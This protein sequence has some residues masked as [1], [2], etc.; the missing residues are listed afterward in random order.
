MRKPRAAQVVLAAAA[1]ALASCAARMASEPPAGAS[2]AG[3][4]KLD[5]AASDDPQKVL[6]KMRAEAFKI[7]ARQY[8]QAQAPAPVARPGKR[9]TT[10]GT[11]GSQDPEEVAPPPPPGP[12]GHRPDPLQRSP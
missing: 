1:A 6:D 11:A 4:W 12:D 7:L 5:P 10:G 3:T 9:G 8:A 2:L